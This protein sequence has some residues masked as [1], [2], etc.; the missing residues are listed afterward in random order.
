MSTRAFD[1][2]PNL[3]LLMHGQVVE[4]DDIACAKRGNSPP[5]APCRG[6]I[7]T[8]SFIGVYGF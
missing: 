4:Y 6:D 2:R 3:R 5:L 7:R 1:R 8:A